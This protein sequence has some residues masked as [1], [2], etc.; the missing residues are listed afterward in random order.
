MIGKQTLEADSLKRVQKE[1]QQLKKKEEA[2]QGEEH[3]LNKK[4]N[5]LFEEQK[6][7]QEELLETQKELQFAMQQEE[8][9]QEWLAAYKSY[10]KQRKK[11]D[12]LSERLNLLSQQNSEQ[13]K[14]LLSL[15][16]QCKEEEQAIFLQELSLEKLQK[17]IDGYNR[18]ARADTQVSIARGIA[19]YNSETD[20]VFANVF[21]RADDAMYQNKAA[22]KERRRQQESSE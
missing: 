7:K 17:E 18:N 22:M 6:A 4:S 9:L 2:L 19:I 10:Q 13:Q 12:T 14:E 5:T 15:R 16:E 21:K 8:A 3:L 11:K 1:W 20:L